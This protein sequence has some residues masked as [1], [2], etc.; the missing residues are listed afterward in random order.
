MRPDEMILFMLNAMKGISKVK[1]LQPPSFEVIVRTVEGGTCVSVSQQHPAFTHAT[2]CADFLEEHQLQE[3]DDIE[4]DMFIAWFKKDA[5]RVAVIDTSKKVWRYL[6]CLACRGGWLLTC[7]LDSL[8][9]NLAKLGNIIV[10]H[11]G[12]LDEIAAT[13]ADLEAYGALHRSV[14]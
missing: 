4:C 11:R 2:L 12:I 5:R 6:L 10:R 13:M 8:P 3:H 1:H 9:Q 7:V 14:L